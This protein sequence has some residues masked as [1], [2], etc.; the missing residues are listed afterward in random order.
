M[1]GDEQSVAHMPAYQ[2]VVL[3]KNTSND[4][5]K[6]VSPVT[7]SN[8]EYADNVTNIDLDNDGQP[9]Q[10]KNCCLFHCSVK[11]KRRVALICLY[12]EIKLTAEY[13]YV[14]VD[15]FVLRESSGSFYF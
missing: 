11:K 13:G 2:W 10:Y 1:N 7:I 12:M 6:A 15:S 3:K 4:K 14:D 9:E 5:V 8:R